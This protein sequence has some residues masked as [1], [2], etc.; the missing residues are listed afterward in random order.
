MALQASSYSVEMEI[1]VHS[2][3]CGGWRSTSLSTN[4]TQPGTKWPCKHSLC[5]Q[6][7]PL[8]PKNHTMEKLP[9]T[10]DALMQHILQVIYQ[11]GIWAT[12]EQEQ[13][14][15]PSPKA[16]GWKRMAQSWVPVWITIPE[17]STACRELIRCSRTGNCCTCNCLLSTS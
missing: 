16:F 3:N 6:I 10:Q 9:P 11:S 1:M 17:V 13:Q 8:L 5:S 14:V 15:I 2:R 4:T 12:G 7:N